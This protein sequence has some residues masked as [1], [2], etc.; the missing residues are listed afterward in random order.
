MYEVDL[1]EDTWDTAGQ[2]VWCLGTVLEVLSEASGSATGLVR[3]GLD[4]VLVAK[5]EITI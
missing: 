3:I 1:A 5:I 4:P 2:E